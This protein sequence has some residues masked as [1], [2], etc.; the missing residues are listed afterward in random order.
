MDI[1]S[2]RN[3]NSKFLVFSDDMDWCKNNFKGDNFIFC[4]KNDVDILDIFRMSLCKHNIISNSSF[5]WWGAWLN[6]NPTKIV[7]APRN[8]FKELQVGRFKTDEMYCPEW[9]IL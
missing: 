9:T 8:W 1:V 6:N 5:S 2:E 3:G 7:V 4:E